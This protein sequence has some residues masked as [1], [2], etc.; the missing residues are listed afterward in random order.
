MAQD[1]RSRVGMNVEGSPP[2]DRQ[3]A[4][5]LRLLGGIDDAVPDL[6]ETAIS[7]PVY[8]RI[9]LCFGGLGQRGG[10]KA[11][12]R[13]R[14]GRWAAEMGQWANGCCLSPA[15]GWRGT[16]V[17]AASDRPPHVSAANPGT[18]ACSYG[19]PPAASAPAPPPPP[20]PRP[21]NQINRPPDPPASMP[22]VCE[23]TRPASCCGPG[24][25]LQHLFQASA[26]LHR[27][28]LR[29]RPAR[30]WTGDRGAGAGRRTR[31]PTYG[32]DRMP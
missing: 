20:L 29:R 21:A 13:D 16:E 17:A 3:P 31:D 6:A 10:R 22:E 4:G 24:L 15:C 28:G 18:P 5:R 19:R 12:S 2:A 30:H 7:K 11:R 27:P 32:A 8:S 9:G 26:G 14:S 1:A 25:P 23:S